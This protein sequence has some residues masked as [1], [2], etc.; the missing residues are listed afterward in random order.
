MH[1]TNRFYS[2]LFFPTAHSLKANSNLTELRLVNCNLSGNDFDGLADVLKDI[3]SLSVLDLSF[4]YVGT[5]PLGN[6]P[7]LIHECIFIYII[8]H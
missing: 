3:S 1:L 2:R 7:K 4:N 5:E 8:S 6:A